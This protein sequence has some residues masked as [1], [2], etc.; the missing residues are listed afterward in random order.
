MFAATARLGFEVFE[1]VRGGAAEFQRGFGG[2]RFDVGRAANAVGA[3]DFFGSC[4]WLKYLSQ[5]DGMRSTL[6]LAGSM[7]TTLNPPGTCDLDG[8][9]QLLFVA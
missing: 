7:L 6:V 4:S 9:A 2:D 3:E 5:L 8:A 1:N